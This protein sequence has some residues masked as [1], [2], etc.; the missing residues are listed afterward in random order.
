MSVADSVSGPISSV[1]RSEHFACPPPKVKD[2]REDEQL[3]NQFPLL[4][5]QPED[6]KSRRDFQEQY[7]I[8]MGESIRFREL[9]AVMSQARRL[10][11]HDKEHG[12][13][14][15]MLHAIHGYYA[16]NYGLSSKNVEH[17]A[18]MLAD[19]IVAS[20]ETIRFVLHEYFPLRLRKRLE[21]TTEVG[22]ALHPVDLILECAGSGKDIHSRLRHYEARRQL[23]F[24]QIEFELQLSGAGSDALNSDLGWFVDACDEHYFLK[25]KSDQLTVIADLD[26]QDEYRVKRF[27]VCSSR[28]ESSRLLPTRERFVVP[29][30]VRFIPPLHKGDPPIP[31]YFETRTKKHIPLK[32]IKKR[33]R[34]HESISDSC[35]AKFIFFDEDRDL[36]AGVKRIR[37]TIARAPGCISGEASNIARAGQIDASNAHSS[38]EYRARKW[39]VRIRNR[40]FELQFMY[41]PFYLNEQVSHGSDNHPLYKLSQYLDLLFPVIFPT[42]LYGLD[43]ANMELRQELWNYQLARI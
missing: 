23:T 30:N 5:P 31:V 9:L 43:W 20:R 1:P 16:P 12:E 32:L 4:I 22:S 35:G 3:I 33:Q 36:V 26:P 15:R 42:E 18:R 17:D 10:G 7:S 27:E 41:L 11:K 2:P 29:L 14:E 25:Q 13:R 37:R 6:A 8:L 40:H 24:A 19:A 28:D 39:D 21:M 38:T 34:R